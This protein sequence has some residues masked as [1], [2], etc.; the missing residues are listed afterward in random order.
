MAD[1]I[2]EA[3]SPE[4]LVARARV[5]LCGS[6]NPHRLARTT[7]STTS[8]ARVTIDWGTPTGPASARRSPERG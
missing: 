8:M 1:S 6:L 2:D 3:T 4:H 7:G 5:L